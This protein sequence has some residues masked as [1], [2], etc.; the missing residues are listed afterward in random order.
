[1]KLID[2]AFDEKWDAEWHNYLLTEAI[3]VMQSDMEPLS[4]L[5]FERYVLRN[6]PPAKVASELG[7]TV[8]AVYINKSRTLDQL[9]RVVRQLEKL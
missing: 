9:R 8:N 7:I 2:C 1:M 5:S 4:W 3:R 6:E